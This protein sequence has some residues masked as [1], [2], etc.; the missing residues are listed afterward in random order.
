MTSAIVLHSAFDPAV[1][2]FSTALAK[3]NKGNKIVYVNFPGNQRV[4]IQTP[5]MSAPF[6]ISS[7]DEV[8][9]GVKSY[10]LDASFRGMEEDPKLA[11]FLDKCRGLDACLVD[12]ATT[13]SREWFGKQKSRESIEDLVRK[14]VRDPN[15]PKWAPTVRFKI[16]THNDGSI[17]TEFFDENQE[18]VAPEYFVKGSAFRAIVELSSV[19]F[20][21]NS[22]GITLRVSQV[23]VVNRPSGAT[24]EKLTGFCFMDEEV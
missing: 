15:D 4:R 5:V 9:T 14:L 12:A 13:N 8:S 20:V 3:T 16:N 17:A 7:F 10:S 24:Q 11:G 22:F 6:G 23:C 19:W 18:R 21:Q 2:E 1:V